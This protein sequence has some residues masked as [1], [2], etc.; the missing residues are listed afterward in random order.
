MSDCK[1]RYDNR[2]MHKRL[3]QIHKNL[4][5]ARSLVDV[6]TNYLKEFQEFSVREYEEITRAKMFYDLSE[7]Q[8]ESCLSR[9]TKSIKAKS[10][11]A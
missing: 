11:S 7:C 9:R 6:L 4:S 1:Y 2:R 8:C 5:L 10:N 3:V